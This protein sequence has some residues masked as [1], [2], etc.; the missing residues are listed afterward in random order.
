MGAAWGG[1]LSGLIYV[2]TTSSGIWSSDHKQRPS[3]LPG[4]DLFSPPDHRKPH[5]PI[6]D[7]KAYV[8]QTVH[9]A[10]S[11]GSGKLW[12]HVD[13]SIAFLNLPYQRTDR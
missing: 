7:K 6:D 10:L 2:M 8:G 12:V 4:A 11:L 9:Q 1:T 5:S 13:P 3:L